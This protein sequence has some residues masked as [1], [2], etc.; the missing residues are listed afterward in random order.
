M[1]P[2]DSEHTVHAIWQGSSLK[3]VPCYYSYIMPAK[4]DVCSFIYFYTQLD[5]EECFNEHKSTRTFLQ[6]H[7]FLSLTYKYTK[8]VIYH[9]LVIIVGIWFAIA[10]AVINA[11]VAFFHAWVYGPMLKLMLIIV[12]ML[13]GWWWREEGGWGCEGG[14]WW[15]CERGCERGRRGSEVGRRG[16]ERGTEERG[17]DPHWI[18]VHSKLKL[19]YNIYLVIWAEPEPN[20]NMQC[21]SH[22]SLFAIQQTPLL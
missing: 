9:I 11:A 19:H 4:A 20:I 21:F 14:R 6:L 7:T 5:F 22:N 8:I 10:W 3:L 1:H 18:Q 16:R 17:S 12:Y 13:R 15:G 2:H